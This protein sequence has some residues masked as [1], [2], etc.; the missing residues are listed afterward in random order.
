MMMNDKIRDQ[1]QPLRELVNR[2]TNKTKVITVASGKGG[3]GKS[4]ISVN[5]ALALRALNLRVLV[6][7]A[8]FGLANV[9]VMLGTSS[10]YNMSHILRGEKTLEE[11]IQEGY[12]GVRFISGGSG[13]Y[14]LLEMDGEQ[15][16]AVMGSLMAVR[17]LADII[18]F[19]LGAG[20]NENIM[21][22]ILASSETIVVTTPEPTAILD[23]Y[24]L[25]KTIIKKD[26]AHTIR[27]IMNKSEN[28]REAENAM[29]GFQKVI[30]RHLNVDI[31]ALGHVLFDG[32]ISKSIKQ[33]T[34][35]LISQPN[36]ATARN[37]NAI[38]QRLLYLPSNPVA[39]S[40]LSKL[41]ARWLG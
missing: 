29:S 7:D 11:I 22:L 28:K 23:A 3:V 19:D 39:Q 13:I 16:G 21:Q 41:F 30:H 9:D 6:I 40:N 2:N 35:I 38:A 4:S 25:I 24:A 17:N 33:Q 14:E 18:L 36:G 10:R 27:F 31:E 32:D 15:V 20:I 34:P 37:I 1:A 12:N 26:N 8:D 5:L